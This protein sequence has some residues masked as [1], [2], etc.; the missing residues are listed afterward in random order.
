MNTE[1]KT[2]YRGEYIDKHAALLMCIGANQDKHG[3]DFNNAFRKNDS[4]F[5]GVLECKMRIAQIKTIEEKLSEDDIAYFKKGF[6]SFPPKNILKM[7]ARAY[8]CH[9]QNLPKLLKDLMMLP[10]TP[11]GAQGGQTTSPGINPDYD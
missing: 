8:E 4:T 10:P 6:D 9:K 1:N 7:A 5:P 2:N 3:A 11:Y